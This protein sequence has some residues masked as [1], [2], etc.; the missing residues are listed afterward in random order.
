[1]YFCFYK[2]FCGNIQFAKNA[3]KMRIYAD[4]RFFH[5]AA[6]DFSVGAYNGSVC[7][8][9]S[10]AEQKKSDVEQL[11]AF[12]TDSYKAQTSPFRVFSDEILLANIDQCLCDAA[13]MCLAGVN[14]TKMVRDFA[15]TYGCMNKELCD[16]FYCNLTQRY[17]AGLRAFSN[18]MVYEPF[19]QSRAPLSLSAVEDDDGCRISL[20]YNAEFIDEAVAQ[21]I[22]DEA[23]CYMEKLVKE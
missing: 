3:S 7:I 11:K 9:L 5:G 16:C 12:H 14:K 18:I 19:K 10:K 21:K 8:S 17:W 22:V 6:D 4:R 1:L 2:A 15:T 23:M 13:Y 20:R